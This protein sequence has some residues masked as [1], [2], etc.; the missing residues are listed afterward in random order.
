MSPGFTVSS[1]VAV[2][3]IGPSVI[4]MFAI[5]LCPSV[6]VPDAGDTVGSPYVSGFDGRVMV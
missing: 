1:K 2:V 3:A 5:T 4:R 6:S